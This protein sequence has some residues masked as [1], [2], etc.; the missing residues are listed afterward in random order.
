MKKDLP[1]PAPL[2]GSQGL[3]PGSPKPSVTPSLPFL[4]SSHFCLSCVVA[5]FSSADRFSLHGEEYGHGQCICSVESMPPPS[6]T[7][8]GDLEQSLYLGHPEQ[9]LAQPASL[10]QLCGLGGEEGAGWAPR[11]SE[12]GSVCWAH[13]AMATVPHSP[14]SPQGVFHPG[15][16]LW[17]PAL[18][19]RLPAPLSPELT[20]WRR[21]QVPNRSLQC[22][23]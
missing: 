14:D 19:A 9:W 8:G 23:V 12:H 7:G 4:L 10:A 1:A 6:C 15:K 17:A 20:I 5:S 11:K 13:K 22:R 16:G 2:W 18:C 3:G 21:K